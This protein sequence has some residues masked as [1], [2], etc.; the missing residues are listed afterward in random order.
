MRPSFIAVAILAS[1]LVLNVSAQSDEAAAVA[2]ANDGT[3]LYLSANNGEARLYLGVPNADS[4]DMTLDP[5]T[6]LVGPGGGLLQTNRVEAASAML[7]TPRNE[8]QI[9]WTSEQRV[10]LATC[11]L[12][13]K[14]GA[15]RA[16]QKASYAG[17]SELGTGRPTAIAFDERAGASVLVGASA[18]EGGT[19]WVARATESKKWTRENIATGQ[20]D[21]RPQVAISKLGV[22]HVVWRNSHGVVWHLENADDGKWLRSGATSARPERVGVAT[23]E[24]AL[25][26]AR[27][28]VLVVLPADKGQLEY[29]LYTGQNWNTNLPLTAGDKRWKK[30][31][32]SQPRLVVDGRSVPWLLFVN[33]TGHRKF[34]YSTRWLGTGWDTIREGRGIFH[35]TDKFL[36]NLAA[37]QGCYVPAHVAAGADEFGLLLVNREASQPLRAHRIRTPAPVARPGADILFLDMLDVGE[38]RWVGQALGTVTKHPANPLLRPSGDPQTIDSHRV[39][40]GGTV[41][42]DGD[43]FKTWYSA[44]NP[45]GDWSKWMDL[46]HLCYG[47][48]KDG[49]AWEKPELGLVEFKGRKNNNAIPGLNIFMPVIPNPDT[50]DAARRFLGFHP[51]RHS[52]WSS[53]DGISWKQQPIKCKLLGP[54]PKWFVYNSVL[55]DPDAPPSRRWRAYGCMCPNEPPVRR[56]IACAYSADGTNFFGHAENPIFQPETSS[57]WDKVHDVAVVKYKGH[58]VMLYQTGNHYDQHLE[59]AVSR[60]GEH[61]V[62]VHDGQP[63]IPQGAGNAWD[64]G[65]HIP[66]RPLVTENEIR[67]YYGAAN[68]QSPTDQPLQY[69]RWKKCRMGLGL[70]T[71][72]IDGWTYLRNAPDH[73]IGFI[74]TVPITVKD[75]KDC[76]LTVNA[77]ADKD[78]YLLAELLHGD[79]DD[80]V[81]GYEQE[82]SDKMDKP[83]VEQVMSWQGKSGLDGVKTGSV[84]IRIIFRGRG[85]GPKLRSIGFRRKPGAVAPPVFKPAPKLVEKNLVYASSVSHL[86]PMKAWM[87]FRPDSKPKPVVVLMHGYGDPVLRH[88]GRRMLGSVRNYAERGLFAIAV[89]LRG[90]EESAGQRDDGGLE[91]MDIYDAVQAALKQHPSETDP[92]CINI[93]G[94][95]GGGGNTF[96]AVTRMPD[97]F[98]N[99]AAF[100]GITDYGHWADT[101]FKGVIQPNVGGETREVPD[102]YLAR[103]SLL[104]VGN[105]ACTTFHF[106]WDEKETI[107]PPW[108]DTEYRRIAREMGRQN[109]TAHESKQTD[110]FRWLHE[111]MDK[112]SAAES[113]RLIVPLFLNRNNPNPALKPEGRLMVLGYLMTKRFQALFGQGNDAVAELS[114]KLSPQEY[115]FAFSRRSSDPDVRGW[116]RI[117]DRNATE[118][119]SVHVDGKDFPWEKTTDGHMVV[120]DINPNETVVVRFK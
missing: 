50:T 1:C 69:E 55:H 41:L 28:Q 23:A 2:H 111:G 117:S 105:N 109:I 45:E 101:S 16:L 66:S 47:T 22:A 107:C 67:L 75:V 92:A 11:S 8:L 19:V 94:W 95:S 112:A 20:G 54:E 83:G 89:D 63:L 70:A 35:V 17:V 99:A 7:V 91:I 108:M 12:A 72:P 18:D 79:N 62:R 118:V 14:G 6:T 65:M 40:N 61:F 44:A 110:K 57:S 58:Y 96:S 100:Y 51:N 81:P 76:V 84:R 115:R 53:G 68:Y 97:L 10:F 27:H 42:R 21:V 113:D 73:H 38:T 104:G 43:G 88:G 71:L 103:K 116:L 48:S 60:D 32:L 15:R 98:S 59:L 120:R 29:S 5:G 80:R 24:P 26:C 46:L 93:I 33:T 114:Y 30:D 49:L 82:N 13:G 9:A 52:L 3:Y 34:V 56:A 31:N 77:E 4:L 85:D 74:T 25:A 86:Q 64:R 102:R 78:H 106:F 87:A 39:F 37:V 119:A 90:R 36:D